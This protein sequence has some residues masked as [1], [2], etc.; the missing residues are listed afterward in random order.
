MARYVTVYSQQVRAFNLVDTLA[1]SGFLTSRSEIAVVGGGISG[2]TAAAAAA[3]RRVRRVA[4]FEKEANTMRLQR[5]SEKRFLH[6]RIYDWPAEKALDDKAGHDLLDWKADSAAEV[7]AGLAKQWDDLRQRFSNLEAPRLGCQQVEVKA[8]RGRW[9]V[10]TGGGQAG[11]F[12]VVVLAV[13]FGRDVTTTPEGILTEGYWTDTSLDGLEFE[14][15]KTWF[16]S[17]Y[18]DGALTD[19]MRLCIMDFRHKAVLEAV[20]QVTREAVGRDLLAAERER[21]SPEALSKEFLQA[22][23]KIKTSLDSTLQKRKVGR[24]V[25]NCPGRDA[26]FSPQSSILN[27]LII[28]YLLEDERFEILEGGGKIED[29]DRTED[30]KRYK[31]TFKNGREPFEADRLIIRHGPRRAFE[32]GFPNQWQA[33]RR[34][35]AQWKSALQ[36]E[37]WTREPLYQQGDFSPGA[38]QRPPLRIDF[39][40]Q[41]GCVIITGSKS[42]PGLTHKQRMRNALQLLKNR[43]VEGR[44]EGREIEIEPEQISAIEAFSSPAAYE[45]AVRALCESDFAVFDITGLESATMLLLGI[46]SVVRR[47]I[48]LTVSQEASPHRSLPFNLAALNPVRLGPQDWLEI[49]TALENGQTSLR[50]QQGVYRDLPAFD[51]VRNLGDKHR[52]QPPDEQV[53]VLRWFDEQYTSLIRDLIAGAVLHAVGQSPTV[54]TTLDSRSPQS[55][56]QRLYAAIRRTQFC[57]ADWTGWRPNVL[58]ETGVRLAVNRIDPVFILCTE[59]PPGWDKEASSWPD[60]IDPSA[61]ALKKFFTPVEF[62]FSDHELIYTRF[63]EHLSPSGP[64]QSQAALSPGR[65]YQ[66]VCDHLPRELEPGGQGVTDMLLEKAQQISGPAVPEEGGFPLLYSE[67]L[68]GQ[69]RKASVEMLL[70]AWHYLDRRNTHDGKGLIEAVRDGRLERDDPALEQLRKVGRQLSSRLRNVSGTEYKE[71]ALEIRKALADLE[72]TRKDKGD[73]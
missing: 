62:T 25:L 73:E 12:D 66:V 70:A 16:V 35:E 43:L 23:Q 22:A 4:V 10:H 18:G 41:I 72:P 67:V 51:A 6:P 21:R 14:S 53:L 13:G 26:L 54:V 52:P 60:R 68:A 69:A 42:P 44:F 27:R 71:I 36:H 33:C 29:P 47:G 40:E 17:G 15:E 58:F 45:R 55:V 2:L 31:I 1:K 39:G 49:T 11:I 37:D 59:L 34:L 30:G 63:A 32:L 64:R 38:S 8:R 3:V 20:D 57:I 48:T 46:R 50:T 5:G 9:E 61:E 7:A 28:A 65:T 56:E 19:L 24:V